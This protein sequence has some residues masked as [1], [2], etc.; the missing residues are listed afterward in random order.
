M[1]ESAG[2]TITESAAK[3]ITD[4][5]ATEGDAALMLRV[6]VSSGGCSGFQYGFDLDA[7]LGDDDL[8]FEHGAV[9][10]LV[11]DVSLQYVGGSVLDYKEELI[12][13]FF[14]LENPNASSTCGCGTSFSI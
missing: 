11:D 3:R 7:A 2:L 8:V 6:A 1:T 5:I 13:S 10:V 9:K 4:L 12:G 14:A